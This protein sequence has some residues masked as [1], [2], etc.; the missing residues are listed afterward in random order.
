[1]CLTTIRGPILH[2]GCNLNTQA[3]DM[4]NIAVEPT[5]PDVILRRSYQAGRALHFHAR[6]QGPFCIAGAAKF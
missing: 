4:I 1:M 5:N 6:Q 2:V 3:A